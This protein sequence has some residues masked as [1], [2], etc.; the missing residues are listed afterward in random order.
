MTRKIIALILSFVMLASIASQVFGVQDHEGEAFPPQEGAILETEDAEASD[1]GESDDTDISDES[2]KTQA[3]PDPDT[4]SAANLSEPVTDFKAL[5]DAVSTYYYAQENITITVGS[6]I[7]LTNKLIIWAIDHEWTLTIRSEDPADPVTLSRGAPGTMIEVYGDATFILEDIILDGGATGAFEN[8]GGSLIVVRAEGTCTLGEGAV[9]QNNYYIYDENDQG[10]IGG[11]VYNA[12][13]LHI[14]GGSIE[15]CTAVRGGGAYNAGN[16]CIAGVS[17]VNCDAIWGGGVYNAD[18]FYFY[19]GSISG[20]TAVNGDGGGVYNVGDFHLLGGEISDCAT[21]KA[22]EDENDVSYFGVGGGVCNGEPARYGF[23]PVPTLANFHFSSG[24]ILRC[25][26]AYGGGVYNGEGEFFFDGGTITNNT[27][28]YELGGGGVYAETTSS[29]IAGGVARALGNTD[30][31]ED[32]SNIYLE[33]GVFIDLGAGLSQNGAAAPG[34]EMRIG[35]TKTADEG[36][37]VTTGSTK[38]TAKYF[39]SDCPEKTIAHEDGALRI[40]VIPVPVDISADFTD[41]SFRTA[42]YELTGITYGDSIFITDIEDIEELLID[43]RNIES[44]A[45]IAHFAALTD[46]DCSGNAL[47]S[48][49]LT[50]NVELVNVDC[51]GNALTSLDLT[52]NMELVNVDCSDNRLTGIALPDSAGLVY[53]DCS[54]NNLTDIALPDSAGLAY[55]DCS[56]NSLANLDIS[57]SPGLEYLHCARNL[58]ISLDVSNNPLL[59][60]LDCSYNLIPSTEFIIILNQTGLIPD[61]T[62]LFY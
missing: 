37:F 33:E 39:F 47:T 53:L 27:S 16:L 48:L 56:G 50:D 10:L 45:G 61:E 34:E 60:Y 13:E 30:V 19:S 6:D 3:A 58:L 36:L 8:G 11:G 29:I 35:V 44:L 38:V 42:I 31:V 25:S 26:A 43:G 62:F 2:A 55:L 40:I 9:L 17:I 12:G 18:E 22:S 20:C 32:E 46:L 49:D 21:Y 14:E 4:A 57:M 59:E 23:G 52:D 54:G 51:S 41:P 24:S 5:S 15:N 28:L 7:A 1:S